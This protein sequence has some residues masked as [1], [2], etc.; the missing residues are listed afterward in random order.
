MSFARIFETLRD[1]PERTVGV[2]GAKWPSEMSKCCFER[3]HVLPK[4]PEIFEQSLIFR[5]SSVRPHLTWPKTQD[6][7]TSARFSLPPLIWKQRQR[8]VRWARRCARIG[9]KSWGCVV[10]SDEKLFTCD[11]LDGLK[12]YWYDL[13]EEKLAVSQRQHGGNGVTIRDAF[14]THGNSNLVHI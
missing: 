12:C 13:R 10:F 3:H 1:T 5:S 4:V 11:G 14:S 9:G 2:K 8:W 7:V 6:C